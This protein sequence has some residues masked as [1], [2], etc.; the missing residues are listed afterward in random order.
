MPAAKAVPPC[1]SLSSAPP[2][3]FSRSAVAATW[4]LAFFTAS[5]VAVESRVSGKAATVGSSPLATQVDACKYFCQLR[6]G[7]VNG[8]LV[9]VRQ[10]L[11][12]PR[13]G[14]FGLDKNGLALLEQFVE[15][16]GLQR[17]ARR[18]VVVGR[19]ALGRFAVVVRAG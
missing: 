17:N 1:V 13:G 19:Q 18:V 15:R 16:A 10:H 12:E 4:V 11:I 6:D 3:A 7:D 5:K 9:F 14:L 8:L 2:L